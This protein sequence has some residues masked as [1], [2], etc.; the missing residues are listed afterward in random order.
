MLKKLRSRQV[1]LD[2]FS[3]LIYSQIMAIIYLIES[4]RDYD[5]VYKIGYT[6]SNN[7]KK[8]RVVNLQTG[9]DGK[10]NIINE[11]HTQHGTLLEKAIQNHF[12]HNKKRGEWY[13]LDIEDVSNFLSLCDKFENN[14]NKLEDNYFIMKIKNKF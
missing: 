12:S 11:Y 4:V 10:L 14:F 3:F 13:E 9:N 1:L 5:T 2:D 6:K 7:S 8:N